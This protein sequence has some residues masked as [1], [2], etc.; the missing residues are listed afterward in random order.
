MT[1]IPTGL[2]LLVRQAKL[3]HRSGRDVFASPKQAQEALASVG[4]SV[5]KLDDWEAA[6]LKQNQARNRVLAA[7]KDY[8][9]ALRLKFFGF[10]GAI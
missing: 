10:L 6:H 9:D 5:A 1:E 3:R 7:K 4:H 2:T 8:E